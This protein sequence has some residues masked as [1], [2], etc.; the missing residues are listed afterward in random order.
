MCSSPTT[1]WKE[2]RIEKKL[3]KNTLKQPAKGMGVSSS[4]KTKW[5]E[6]RTGE[7]QRNTLKQPAKGMGVSSS[8]NSIR[9]KILRTKEG[10][11]ESTIAL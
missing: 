7:K 4:P 2:N 10:R 1:K 11:P 9:N 5:K 8:P 3:K 6:N